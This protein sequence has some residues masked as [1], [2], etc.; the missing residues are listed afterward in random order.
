[1]SL[2]TLLGALLADDTR[3]QHFIH[4]RPKLAAA[5]EQALQDDSVPDGAPAE[6]PLSCRAQPAAGGHPFKMRSHFEWDPGEGRGGGKPGENVPLPGEQKTESADTAPASR[7]NLSAANHGAPGD[8]I[9]FFDSEETRIATPPAAASDSTPVT[10]KPLESPAVTA[11]ASAAND[12]APD[13]SMT[14]FDHGETRIATPPA[15]SDPFDWPGGETPQPQ[16]TAPPEPPAENPPSP[17]DTAGAENPAEPST[18]IPEPAMPLPPHTP[19]SAPAQP[20]RISLSPLPPANEGQPYERALPP[21]APVLN[22]AFAQDC[23]LV[24]DG[25][26][27]RIHGTPT[28]SGDIQLTITINHDGKAVEITQPLHINPDPKSLWQDLPSDQTAPFAKPDSAEDLQD[29][30]LGRLLAARVRGRSHAHVGSYCD[31]DYRLASHDASGVHLIIV[32]DGAG[33]ASHARYGSQLAVNAAADTILALLDDPG[34]PHHKLAHADSATR[35]QI[36][37]NLIANALHAAVSAHKNAAQQAGIAEKAL[38]CTLLI[39]LTLP[40]ADGSWY[41]AGYQVGDGAAALWHPENGALHLL[42]VA[43]SGAYSGETQF[44]TA[45]QLQPDDIQRRIRT[46]ETAAAP[47][48]ILMTDGVSDPKFETDAAL[49]NPQRWQALWDELQAPLTAA[50]PKAALHDWLGF[51]SRGNH[52][53]RTIAFFLPATDAA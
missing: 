43:D 28:T 27:R 19:T 33:S 10:E 53:D 5:L 29:T 51:W 14:F 34:K 36:A 26:A 46:I 13:D 44:L 9:A 1:M 7:D 32:A 6:N 3:L 50:D 4:T 39:A 40:L 15:A 52:D 20:P 30:V 21:D 48:V 41:S 45:A 47:T 38:S 2:K 18:A 31:D 17:P 35:K 11:T 25:D 42:G 12:A 16:N 24:W 8:G 49:E 37:D 22:I 23:G